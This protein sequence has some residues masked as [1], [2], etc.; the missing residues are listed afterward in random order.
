MVRTGNI[1]PVR[2][3]PLRNRL[4]QDG[5]QF[6]GH[7]KLHESS[8]RQ[9]VHRPTGIVLHFVV[10]LGEARGLRAQDVHLL[11]DTTNAPR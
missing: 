10:E 4:Q 5:R 3:D 11:F 2:A 6:V 1:G 7:F 8:A 9:G